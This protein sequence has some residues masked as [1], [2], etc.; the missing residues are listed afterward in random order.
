MIII[1]NIALLFAVLI[2]SFH[3]YAEVLLDAVM[4]NCLNKARIF[5]GQDSIDMKAKD[6]KGRTALI[7]AV[8]TGSAT[9]IEVLLACSADVNAKINSVKSL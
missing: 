2:N 6:S 7:Y 3:S 1:Y 8:R 5:L 4:E 9:L